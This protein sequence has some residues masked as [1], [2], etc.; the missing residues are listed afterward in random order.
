MYGGPFLPQQ[1]F[2]S[3]HRPPNHDTNFRITTQPPQFMTQTTK[4]YDTNPQFM[5]QTPESR[6]KLA[7]NDTKGALFY[8]PVDF[9]DASDWHQSV[10][11]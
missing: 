2:D 1:T 7:V 5:T 4:L 10:Q 9:T 8:S 3:R 11:V 6:H